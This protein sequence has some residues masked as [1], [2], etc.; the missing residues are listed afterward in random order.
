MSHT[1]FDHENPTYRLWLR[2]LAIANGSVCPTC[3]TSLVHLAALL[4][5][6]TMVEYCVS[7]HHLEIDERDG[8]D[9]TPL[10]YAVLNGQ[11]E[12]VKYLLSQK[13]NPNAIDVAGKRPLHIACACKSLA[14]ISRLMMSSVRLEALGTAVVLT[15]DSRRPGSI[16]DDGHQQDNND[17]HQKRDGNNHTERC[18]TYL[19]SRARF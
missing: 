19:R 8:N 10:F 16:L 1:L 12:T 2:A 15:E 3:D 13:A 14:Y 11:T 9:R 5:Y 17:D 4:G 18:I 7:R 6:P